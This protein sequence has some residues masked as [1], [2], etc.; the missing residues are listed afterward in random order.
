MDCVWYYENLR[1]WFF[2]RLNFGSND[3]FYV[4]RF[5]YGFSLVFGVR[6][7]IDFFEIFEM[8][9]VCLFC[10]RGFRGSGVC[11]QQVAELGLEFRIVFLLFFFVDSKEYVSCL[12]FFSVQRFQFGEDMW[13]LSLKQRT[14]RGGLKFLVLYCWVYFSVEIWSYQFWRL[15]GLFSID[16]VGLIEERKVGVFFV[17]GIF[18]RGVGY[19]LVI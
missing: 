17:F 10:S 18:R 16:G 8:S 1:G 3:N 19:S 12:D 11:C 9:M 13:G 15:I 4:L 14:E 2:S 7:I 6:Y 5:F